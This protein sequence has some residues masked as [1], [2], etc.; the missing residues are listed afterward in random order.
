MRD[1]FHAS[2]KSL[3]LSTPL[4]GMTSYG[5]KVRDLFLGCPQRRRR[6]RGEEESEI[7]IFMTRRVLCKGLDLRW[8]GKSRDMI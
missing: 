7:K 2:G 4:V 8:N 1:G 3:R 5:R 6:E